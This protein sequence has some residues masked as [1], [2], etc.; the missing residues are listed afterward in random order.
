MGKQ[1]G[2][3]LCFGQIKIETPNRNQSEAFQL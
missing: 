3:E 1:G 2:E